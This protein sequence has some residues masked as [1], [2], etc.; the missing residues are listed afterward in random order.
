[1]H[2][3]A[4]KGGPLRLPS[5]QAPPACAGVQC[6]RPR[7]ASHVAKVANVSDDVTEEDVQRFEKIAA[8]LA[9]LPLENLDSEGGC[10][11]LC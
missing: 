1:M 2:L 10:C 9:N 8:A 5:R 6:A 7:P 11:A 4:L 3:S